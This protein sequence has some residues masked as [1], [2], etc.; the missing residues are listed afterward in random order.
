MRIFQMRLTGDTRVLEPLHDCRKLL[1]AFLTTSAAQP[2]FFA[3]K[4][5]PSCSPLTLAG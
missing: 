3:A 1:V 4:L 2:N 5:K